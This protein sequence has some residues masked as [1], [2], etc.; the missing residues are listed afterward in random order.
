M[1]ADSGSRI[2]DTPYTDARAGSAT[3]VL[4]TGKKGVMISWW[5]EAPKVSRRACGDY[6][7]IA[8]VESGGEAR[9]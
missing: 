2:S 1:L 7:L 8:T 3:N 4:E 9:A 5:M 6:E